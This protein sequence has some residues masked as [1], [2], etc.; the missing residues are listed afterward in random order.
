MRHAEAVPAGGWGK[1]DAERPLTKMGVA[2]L[3]AGL[4]EM[5]RTGFS[6]ALIVTSP[7]LR[8]VETARLVSKVLGLPD[9]VVR[10][11]IGSG[12]HHSALHKLALELAAKS[13]VL[14]VGHMPEIAIYGTRIANEPRIM[15]EG[16]QPA[17]IVAFDYEDMTQPVGGGKLLW[18]RKIEDWKTL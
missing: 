16:L 11:E 14:I 1:S 15:D 2:K 8:A 10:N 13:P 7:Y 18:W 12:A 5:K 17:D 9:P 6:V 4:K 3:E